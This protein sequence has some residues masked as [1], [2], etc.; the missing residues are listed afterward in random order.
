MKMNIK[1]ADLNLDDDIID[2]LRKKYNIDAV[3]IIKEEQEDEFFDS[4]FHAG[5]PHC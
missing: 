5:V 4:D 1:G 2:Y 3:D